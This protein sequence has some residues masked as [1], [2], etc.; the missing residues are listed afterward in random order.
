MNF[1]TIMATTT[2]IGAAGGLGYGV[3]NKNYGQS[4]YSSN[5]NDPY[6]G[7]S[8]FVIHGAALGAAAGLA[9]IGVR[10]QAHQ[11]KINSLSDETKDMLRMFGAL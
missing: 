11:K 4:I 1:S 6:I 8:D 7:Y 9:T 3:Y 10:Y 5:I 2:G